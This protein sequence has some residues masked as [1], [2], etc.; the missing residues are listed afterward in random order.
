MLRLPLGQRAAHPFP[1]WFIAL[2][3]GTLSSLAWCPA[4]RAQNLYYTYTLRWTAPGDDSSLGRA[5]AYDIRTS[6][7]PITEAN[8][9]TALPFPGV[10][11]PQPAG[12]RESFTLFG[13]DARFSY[14]VAMKSVDEVGNWSKMSD[15]L[16]I[17]TPMSAASPADSVTSLELSLPWPNPAR[18][19][20]HFGFALPRSGR[21]EMEALDITGRH[22]RTLAS[23]NHAAGRSEIVWNLADD[24]GRP[25]PAGV[26][27]V[28]GRLIDKVM[29]RALTVVR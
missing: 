6:T 13:L 26:Y 25:V 27:L 11:I 5:K 9:S 24:Q 8:W 3:L 15:V 12:A 17:H 14:Y 20:A 4:V 29:T 10:P 1:V 2:T 18:N 23:G 16:I 19:G 21:V 22:I 28:R 7:Y